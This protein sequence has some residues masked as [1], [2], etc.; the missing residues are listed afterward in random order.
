MYM[1]FN[2]NV[3]GT[4]RMAAGALKSKRL[5]AYMAVA[6][7][8]GTALDVLNRVVLADDDE[9]GENT[10]DKISD[11]IKARALIVMIPGTDGNFA[12]IPLPYGFNF[13]FAFGRV[14]GEFA[15]KRDYAPWQAAMVLAQTAVEAFSPFGQ[16]ATP[17]QVMSPSLV[18]PVVYALENKDWRGAPVYK[19]TTPGRGPTLPA[20]EKGLRTTPLWAKALAREIAEASDGSVEINPGIVASLVSGYTSGLGTTV[21][22]TFDFAQRATTG[23]EIPL[24]TVPLLNRFAGEQTEGMRSGRFADLKRRALE[25][26]G[27]VKALRKAGKHEEAAK[28]EREK[29]HLK[30]FLQAYKGEQKGLTNLYKEAEAA[31]LEEM[32]RTERNQ[33]AKDWEERRGAIYGRILRRTNQARP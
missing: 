31:E 4:A 21:S 20:S 28:L 7:G 9:D 8:I 27:E 30:T 16:A 33:A 32:S 14:M 29:P 22:Q 3:Q 17:A 5:W 26:D 6:A 11:A 18:D 12:K 2:A 19:E 23:Q 13:P 15:T 1:F 10:Y 25:F 24:G